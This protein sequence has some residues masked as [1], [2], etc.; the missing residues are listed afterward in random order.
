MPGCGAGPVGAVLVGA[1][2]VV[3]LGADLALE[4]GLGAEEWGIESR[5]PAVRAAENAAGIGQWV[6]SEYEEAV[7]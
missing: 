2:L 7:L 6:L 5:L 4:A 3:A 1:A